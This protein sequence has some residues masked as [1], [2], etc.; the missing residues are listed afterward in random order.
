MIKHS[1]LILP[2]YTTEVTK[3]TATVGHHLGK[4]DFLGLSTS[5]DIHHDLHHC[6][7]H[8]KCPHE[9]R[10]LVKHFIIHDIPRKDNIDL[11]GEKHRRWR[12]F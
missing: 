9:I 3:E 4:S 6:L 1:F 10:V 12:K 7:V 2:T 8:P 11:G 5:K